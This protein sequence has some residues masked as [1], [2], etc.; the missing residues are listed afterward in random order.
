MPMSR[1]LSTCAATNVPSS[2]CASF[3]YM[4]VTTRARMELQHRFHGV[5]H[6][7]NRTPAQARAVDEA[8]CAVMVR[9]AVG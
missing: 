8:G 6:G 2:G 3:G 1:R 9:S 7:E 5:G 4:F